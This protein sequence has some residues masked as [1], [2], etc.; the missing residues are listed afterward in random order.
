MSKIML[1]RYIKGDSVVHRLD[2]RAKLILSFAFIII[3]FLANNWQTY[4]VLTLFTLMCVALAKVGIRFFWRGVRP[5]IGIILLTV[6]LQVFFT[7]GG[8]VYW[9][10]SI[11]RLTDAGLVFGAYVLCRFSLIIMMSTL[12]TLTTPPLAIARAF[13]SIMQPLKKLHVPVTEIALMMSIALRFVPTLLDE[14]DKIINAQ[15]SRG[16]DFGTGSIRQR[17]KAVIPL[18]IPLFVAALGR[19]EDLALAMEARGYRT[20]G[21]RTRLHTAHWRCNDTLACGAFVVLTLLLVWLRK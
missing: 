1:G 3:I 9:Q 8:H 17:I 18:L 13:E 16:V 20:G 10:W 15:R 7:T 6:I 21:Q 12:F 4:A 14:T 5:L 2:A 19:A 11:L